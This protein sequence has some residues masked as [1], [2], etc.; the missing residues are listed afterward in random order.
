LA[1]AE[2]ALR[3]LEVEV[4]DFGYGPAHAAIVMLEDCTEGFEPTV[5][6]S[7]NALELIRESLPGI[8]TREYNSLRSG[9]FKEFARNTRP[10]SPILTMSR[11]FAGQASAAGRWVCLLDQLDWMWGPH[12]PPLPSV[13]LHLVPLWVRD[14][15]RGLSDAV[16]VAP[17][18]SR[19]FRPV[20]PRPNV[21]P[22]I[23]GF[24]GMSMM[25]DVAA[26]DFYASWVL[27]GV[28]P[29]L[30]GH[31]RVTEVLVVGGSPNLESYV[32][33]ICADH[34]LVST[35]RAVPPDAYGEMLRS[36]AHQI[37]SPG[38]ATL[39]ESEALEIAPLLQPGVNKSMLLQLQSAI[40][41]GYEWAAPWPF[42]VEA[43]EVLRREPQDKSLA[44]LDQRLVDA[45][46]QDGA[47]NWLTQAVR[48][49][50]D[51]PRA[52]S[53]LRLGIAEG[54][55]SAAAVLREALIDRGPR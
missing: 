30:M 10:G 39:V 52:V 53:P 40:T 41:R 2:A 28:L 38:L 25:A 23:V 21:G 9:S 24:G 17:L 48:D 26:A 16:S 50:L 43:C 12:D 42:H 4:T 55:P 31:P 34:P 49:Y 19:S 20:L 44:W 45:I 6:S 33:D 8:R 47:Q 54:A 18:L 11:A 3:P 7:G 14:V 22:A 35:Y 1:V 32:A 5:W 46:R 29:E 37:L 36:S 27:R 51:R 13:D 15:R